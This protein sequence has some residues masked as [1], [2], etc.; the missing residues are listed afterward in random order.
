MREKL[1]VLK[2]LYSNITKGEWKLWMNHWGKAD[3]A[4]NLDREAN[5]DDN[6]INGVPIEYISTEMNPDNAWFITEFV[7][8]F[9]DIISHIESLTNI[10]SEY[11]I[12]LTKIRKALD[13]AGV[14]DLEFVEE[15][16]C[17]RCLSLEERIDLLIED[18]DELEYMLWKEYH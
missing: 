1:E 8:A 17:D 14:K 6:L 7:K 18:R 4:S 10:E 12:K 9:P 5:D 13:K 16:N 2:R 11:D 3:I 15:H